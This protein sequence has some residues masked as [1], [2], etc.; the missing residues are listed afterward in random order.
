M[1]SSRIIVLN[2]PLG[3]PIKIS[4][5]HPFALPSLLSLKGVSARTGLDVIK[6]LS[7]GGSGA[8]QT[9]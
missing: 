1:W 4:Q 9:P 6:T 2:F 7:E 3:L 5:T 8:I